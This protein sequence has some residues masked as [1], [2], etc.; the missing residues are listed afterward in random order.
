MGPAEVH[1]VQHSTDSTFGSALC[2]LQ[3][4]STSAAAGFMVPAIGGP[5]NHWLQ[6]QWVLDDCGTHWYPH[7]KKLPSFYSLN[8]RMIRDVWNHHRHQLLRALQSNLM[9]FENGASCT[10]SRWERRL[11]SD[12]RGE[13]ARSMKKSVDL[14]LTINE[15][16]PGIKRGNGNP[17]FQRYNVIYNEV[18]SS[19]PRLMTRGYRRIVH[20]TLEIEMSWTPTIRFYWYSW[21]QCPT[22]CGPPVI[23]WF[24]NPINYSYKYHKP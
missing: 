10:N 7:S 12:P 8:S 18:F 6:N 20:H 14:S 15:H 9:S 13:V 16:Y 1:E 17:F 24:I 21:C 2:R 19:Q 23:S 3:M 11:F 5:Q 22:M 4:V